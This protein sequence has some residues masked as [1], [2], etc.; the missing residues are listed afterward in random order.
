[1]WKK[2][3]NY[4]KKPPNDLEKLQPDFSEEENEEMSAGWVGVFYQNIGITAYNM[5]SILGINDYY[6]NR[7]IG[8]M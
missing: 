6:N 8:E 7:K 1:M 2:T 4:L 3:K 5:G